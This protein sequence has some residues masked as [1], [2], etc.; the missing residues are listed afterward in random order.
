MADSFAAS[1]L[2][3]AGQAGVLLGWRPGEFWTA[4]PAELACVLGAM[5]AEDA[6]TAPPD[7][8]QIKH[9]QEIFPDG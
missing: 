5:N 9:L 7:R 2:R 8:N 1:A 4:T 6:V 3:L